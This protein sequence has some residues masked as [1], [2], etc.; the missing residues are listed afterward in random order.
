MTKDLIHFGYKGHDFE[1]ISEGGVR[2]SIV[3]P[4]MDLMFDVGNQPIHHI[5]IGNLFL[6]HAH[7]DHSSGLPYYVSQRS[8][9]N[10][11]PPK[12]FVP[13]D[14]Y[15]DLVSIMN[16]YQK[17][18]GFI[19]Q[20]QMFPI[21][22]GE[23]VDI[24]SKL[25]VKPLPTLHRIPSQGYTIFEKNRKLKQEFQGVEG[26]ELAERKKS[27]EIL[28]EEKLHPVISFSGDTQI[29]YVLENPE[30]QKSKIL[31]LECTYLDEKRNVD[32]AR[33]WGHLHLDE[34]A[35][36]ASKFQNERLVLIHFSKRYSFREIRELV[37]AKLPR[38]LWERTHCFIPNFH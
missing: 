12:I 33:Q 19:Y 6:T 27:G 15:D 34:I 11:K 22:R 13:E 24:S 30:V 35:A 8:L 23:L 7:L 1:G 5:H 9:R 38:D 29:E 28:T 26:R 25:S 4:S 37:K 16:L 31:F 36:H 32:R 14:I 3:C 20:Y 2:T 10:L 21:K 18:E 17:I